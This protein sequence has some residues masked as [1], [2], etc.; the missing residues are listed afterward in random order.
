MSQRVKPRV[1]IF[2]KPKAKSTILLTKHIGKYIDRINKYLIL[3]IVQV[4]EKNVTAIK[5][6]GI[7]RTPT[8]IHNRKQYVSLEKIV[9]ILTPPDESKD[10]YGVD[11]GSPDE[12]VHKYHD[13]VINMNDDGEEDDP[14]VRREDEIRRKM[15]AFQKRRPEMQGVNEDKY[16]RGG[17]KVVARQ[18]ARSKFAN[19]DEFRKASRVD[20]VVE[21]PTKKYIDEQD[22]DAILEDYYN[23]EADRFGRKPNRK[24]IR[25]SGR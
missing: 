3:D 5:K 11:V 1:Q 16:I 20:D 8:L 7:S 23:M 21:T 13:S 2:V 18:A 24:P 22:G 19:D 12:L 15:A 17:R 25:W 10:Q 4:T 9:R 14:S 6:L